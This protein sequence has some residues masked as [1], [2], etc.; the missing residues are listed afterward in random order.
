M[1]TD[2]TF[3][4]PNMLEIMKPRAKSAALIASGYRRKID[5]VDHMRHNLWNQIM[6]STIIDNNCAEQ[7]TL[8]NV[9]DVLEF[10]WMYFWTGGSVKECKMPV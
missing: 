6:S 9:H 8:N 3:H 5:F 1:N 4:Y 7:L 2:I 10:I